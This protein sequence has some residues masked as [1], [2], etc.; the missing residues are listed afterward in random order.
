MRLNLWTEI[1]T[2]AEVAR[3]GRIS[4][5]AGTLG[6]HHSSVIRHIDA[7]EGRLGAKLFQRS[8]RGY[9]PTEAGE[10]LMRT[11]TE[12]GDQLDQMMARIETAR[13]EISGHLTLTVVPG[14]A[15][16][17]L[18]LLQRYSQRHPLVQI[19]F[20]ADK[21]AFEIARGEAHIALRAGVKPSQPDY[22]VSHVF[23][24]THCLCAS[25]DYIARHGRPQDPRDLAKHRLI[26]G[27]E[28]YGGAKFNDWLD[29]QAPS[30]SF[31]LRTSYSA[32]A[33]QAVSSGLGIGFLPRI[34]KGENVI[35]LFPDLVNDDWNASIWMVTHT[36]LH[37]SPK[38][39][40]LTKFIQEEA[41][42][43]RLLDKLPG[44]GQ[45]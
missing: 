1:R 19:S 11:A 34:T 29:R 40:S 42:Q 12:V 38:V 13:D 44:Q 33:Y 2:A 10:D 22:V 17:L 27:E 23:D 26:G 39:Q 15:D 35:D 41:K 6:M 45:P 24:W 25:T 14:L 28:N 21:R 7:L 18:P 5:A 9:T 8:A 4:A 3:L 36:D 43:W 16:I 32:A 20:S 30:E 31:V 37:R